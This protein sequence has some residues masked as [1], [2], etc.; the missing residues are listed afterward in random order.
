MR[1]EVKKKIFNCITSATNKI[2]AITE[3]VTTSCTEFKE[4]DNALLDLDVISVDDVT[5][6]HKDEEVLKN[7]NAELSELLSMVTDLQTEVNNALDNTNVGKLI[8]Q[9]GS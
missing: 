1:P 6:V 8:I 5:P 9:I 7:I 4:K 2:D 3:E